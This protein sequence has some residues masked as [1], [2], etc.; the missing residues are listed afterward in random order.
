MWVNIDMGRLKLAQ[1]HVAVNQAILSLYRCQDSGLSSGRVF[2]DLIEAM[3][4]ENRILLGRI[5]KLLAIGAQPATMILPPERGAEI[6]RI[7]KQEALDSI[8][9]IRAI[10]AELED[11]YRGKV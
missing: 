1:D 3:A 6:Y 11:G 10:L 4:A 9:E 7:K 2:V 8:N 5:S